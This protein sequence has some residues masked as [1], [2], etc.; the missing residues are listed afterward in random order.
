MSLEQ[1]LTIDPVQAA[2]ILA[3]LETKD[4]TLCRYPIC[5]ELR[6][7][8]TGTGRPAVY[9]SDP[10]HNAVTSHRA[11]QQLK[12]TAAL[13]TQQE[14][15]AKRESAPH[16]ASAPVESL[17]N[18][19][20]G[21]I[22]LLQGDLERYVSVLVEMSDPDV[23]AAQIRSALDQAETR[24]AE[25]VQ[26]ASTER[27]LRLSAENAS[28]AARN[29]AQAERDAAELAISHMEDA[30]AKTLRVIEETK[31]QIIATQVERDETIMRV[32]DEAQHQIE[33]TLQQTKKTIAKAED[34]M[35]TAKDEAQ[36]AN[37]RAHDAE[38]DA[39][40]RIETAE[41]LVSEANATLD[42]ERTEVDRLRQELSDTIAESRRQLE[43][44]HAD[45]V[46]SSERERVERERLWNELV[47]TRKQLEQ[48]TDRADKLATTND[49]LRDK[50]LENQTRPREQPQQL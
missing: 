35:A 42:R 2:S 46:S 39:H 36:Q 17:R 30:E 32:R 45:S 28:V 8:S 47:Y 24:I 49:T 1:K 34:A 37:T 50:L 18:S 38:V 33:E 5:Q 3:T 27:S 44:T 11:R 21:R 14:T 25:A 10:D 6:Q 22:T 19:V 20:L 43:A 29:E 7:A 40:S 9:C 41:R 48:V 12:A 15:P 16:P 31:Q 26:N 23:I 13:E 4:E